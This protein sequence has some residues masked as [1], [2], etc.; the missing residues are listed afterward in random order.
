M[1][2]TTT[3]LAVSSDRMGA[4]EGNRGPLTSHA[5][6]FPA[7]VLYIEACESGSMFDGLLERY[8]SVLG[9]TAS[10]AWESSWGTYC[11]SWPPVPQPPS[12]SPSPLPDMGMGTCLGDLFSVAWM[13]NAETGDLTGVKEV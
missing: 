8:I 2:S 11:P 12:P 9:V 10:N 3:A 13:E 7:Q 1:C 6:A 5:Q 4:V